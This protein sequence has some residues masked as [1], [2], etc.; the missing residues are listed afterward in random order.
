MDVE[1]R[2]ELC[3]LVGGL[4]SLL[5]QL[6]D[7]GADA[8]PGDVRRARVVEPAQQAA[9]PAHDERAG[10]FVPSP[11]VAP[12]PAPPQRE[13]REA[14]DERPAPSPVAKPVAPAAEPARPQRALPVVGPRAPERGVDPV[15]RRVRLEQIAQEVAG[16]TRCALFQSRSQTVFARGNPESELMFVGEGPGAEEDAQGLPFVGAAGQLLDKMIVAMGYAADDVYIANIVK[17]RPP[18]NRKPLPVEMETCEGYLHEQIALVQPKVIVALGATAVEGLLKISGIT[19]LRGTWRLYRGEVPVMPTF[20]PAYLLRQPQ[21]K[22]LVWSD[23]QQV[24]QR[25]GRAPTPP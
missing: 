20:H 21:D 8:V 16:C 19:R 2:D 4:R 10:R 5:E 14:R 23:L 24:M 12:P 7:S 9:A 18:S 6:V 1:A 17:C 15:A 22:R 13:A 11:R 3:T 25:L